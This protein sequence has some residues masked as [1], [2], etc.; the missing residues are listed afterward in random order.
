MKVIRTIASELQTNSYLILA[1]KPTMIDTGTYADIILN[2]LKKH[3]KPKEL[4]Y[5]I[6]THFHYDHTTVTSIIKKETSAQVLI[7]ELDVKFL[8]FK[9][10]KTLKDNE[11]I[12]LGDVKLKVIHTSG[13]TPGGICLY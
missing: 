13:H 6:L 9:P 8:D 12:D 10:D 4:E 11:I 5:I 2:N 3:I 1:K 7:H